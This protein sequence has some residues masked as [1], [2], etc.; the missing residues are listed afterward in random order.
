MM[1]RRTSI[2]RLGTSFDR[3]F[4]MVFLTIAQDH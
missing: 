3:G 1:S 4:S 2:G